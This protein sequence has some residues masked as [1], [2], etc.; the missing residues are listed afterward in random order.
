MRTDNPPMVYFCLWW[1]YDDPDGC[2]GES[3]H[4]QWKPLMDTM[5]EAG[6]KV[7]WW[8]SPGEIANRPNGP[9]EWDQWTLFTNSHEDLSHYWTTQPV[10][11]VHLDRTTWG[12]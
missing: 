9:K 5:K 8:V 10:A 4:R 6:Y 1:K 11:I 3:T 7:R 2:S 12:V